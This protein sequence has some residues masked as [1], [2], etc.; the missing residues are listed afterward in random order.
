MSGEF[1]KEQ[2]PS[3]TGGSTRECH[4][5][6][7]S[8]TAHLRGMNFADGE[9][10]L[11][12]TQN[13]VP[14][15]EATTTPAAALPPDL[16]HQAHAAVS[17]L[18]EAMALH[19]ELVAANYL[20]N[21]RKYLKATGTDGALAISK[22]SFT[23]IASKGT[24][25]TMLSLPA[26]LRVDRALDGLFGSLSLGTKV[27]GGIVL[28][29]LYD[30][31]VELL[32]DPTGKKLRAAFKAG[33]DAGVDAMAH[34]ARNAMT[35]RLAAHGRDA[36]LLDEL[37]RSIVFAHSPETLAGL[38]DWVATQIPPLLMPIHDD[39]LFEGML[40]TW[41][42]QRAGDEEDANK[43]TDSDTYDAAHERF[44]T[45]GNLARRD[46][47]IHQCRFELGRLG[48]DAEPSL[49]LWQKQL[50]SQPPTRKTGEVV[51][52][53]GPLRFQTTRFADP[54]RFI[55]TIRDTKGEN[56]FIFSAP[57]FESLF[58]PEELAQ[59]EQ[60]KLPEGGLQS[61]GYAAFMRHNIDRST[62][63]LHTLGTGGLKLTCDVELTDADGAIYVDRYK[64]R[65]EGLRHREDG[66]ARDREDINMRN[67]E[68]TDSPD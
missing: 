43:H 9:A 27:L 22:T 10:A 37:R 61:A 68:W 30:A 57:M 53:L 48:V 11:R 8:H 45:D 59:A 25:K 39:S 34:V 38:E 47:F 2:Q 67:T 7:R 4:P 50:T 42:L 32:F 14:Q 49:S 6:T 36:M 62:R 51:K 31:L 54:G 46:L 52:A 20:E 13:F 64:Y 12:P 21:L 65:L 15:C 60:E 3:P 29:F 66:W 58:D 5:D 26:K 44:A 56:A 35:M 1:E 55:R 23:G 63:I 18:S 40:E 41:V 19:R 24:T 33:H 17:R 28:G 16:V